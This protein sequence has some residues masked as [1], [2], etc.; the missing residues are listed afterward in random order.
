M[1]TSNPINVFTEIY[2][3]TDECSLP[4]LQN[5][6]IYDATHF[7]AEIGNARLKQDKTEKYDSKRLLSNYKQ[8]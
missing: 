4:A 5:D 6:V 7:E 2:M 8:R 1:L 3:L